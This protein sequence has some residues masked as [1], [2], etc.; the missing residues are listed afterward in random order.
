VPVEDLDQLEFWFNDLG[1]LKYPASTILIKDRWK[2]I[3]FM[4]C[5]SRIFA[6]EPYIHRFFIARMSGTEFFRV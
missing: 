5:G 3:G 1:L 2:K 6:R 4:P